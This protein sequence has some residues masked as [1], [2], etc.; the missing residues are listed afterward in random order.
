MQLLLVYVLCTGA[1]YVKAQ[2]SSTEASKLEL[3]EVSSS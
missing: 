1:H 2:S 3:G